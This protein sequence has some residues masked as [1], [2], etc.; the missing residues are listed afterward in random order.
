MGGRK[1]RT[2]CDE[3]ADWLIARCRERP[4]T[5]SHL[6]GELLAERGL[7]VDRRWVWA[8][9][10]AHCLSLKKPV[11]RSAPSLSPGP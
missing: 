6:V 8:L 9:P 4:F 1:P 5:I 7:M 3:H 10:H 2:L 11:R